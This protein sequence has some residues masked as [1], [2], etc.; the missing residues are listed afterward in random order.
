MYSF[1]NTRVTLEPDSVDNADYSIFITEPSF[2][3]FGF[4]ILKRA[5]MYFFMDEAEF[6]SGM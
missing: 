1:G 3:C 4:I 2:Y 6:K 5:S